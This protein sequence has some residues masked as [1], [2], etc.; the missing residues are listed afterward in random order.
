MLEGAPPTRE[1]AM[2][3]GECGMLCFAA[4]SMGTL[5]IVRLF[6][7]GHSFEGAARDQYLARVV[8]SSMAGTAMRELGAIHKTAYQNLDVNSYYQTPVLVFASSDAREPEP[9]ETPA[10]FEQWQTRQR[11]YLTSLPTK[12][13]RGVDLVVVPNSTHVT[14]I[15]GEAQADFV[16]RRILDFVSQVLP[17]EPIPPAPRS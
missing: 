13:S 3:E 17:S 11:A 14:M 10:D 15:L 5:G 4:G 2:N 9:G 1:E 12:S 16:S 6:A 8:R 7:T